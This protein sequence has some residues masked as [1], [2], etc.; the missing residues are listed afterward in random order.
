M[1]PF[2]FFLSFRACTQLVELFRMM[3]EV[4]AFYIRFRTNVFLPNGPL[5]RGGRTV[6]VAVVL[7]KSNKWLQHSRSTTRTFFE[8]CNLRWHYCC[9][10]GPLC[11]H[12]LSPLC[13]PAGGMYWGGWSQMRAGAGC[14]CGSQL[15]QQPISP[16]LLDLAPK[17]TSA[18]CIT[19]PDVWTRA[20]WFLCACVTQSSWMC[21]ISAF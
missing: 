19:L 14:V 4:L 15:L 2:F 20:V 13:H 7:I 8:C 5:R 12:Q 11:K 17:E 6:A 3:Q 18:I 21:V 1:L 9:L 16:V 10:T